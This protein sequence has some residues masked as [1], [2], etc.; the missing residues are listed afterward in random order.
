MGLS[1]FMVNDNNTKNLALPEKQGFNNQ[2][3][4]PSPVFN[5]LGVFITYVKSVTLDYHKLPGIF[6]CKEDN[7][8]V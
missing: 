5:G 8:D 3:L 6:Y 1:L 2:S 4:I 7:K